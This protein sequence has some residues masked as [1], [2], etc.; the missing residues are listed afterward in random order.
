MVT[1]HIVVEK[2]VRVPEIVE[3]LVPVERIITKA[4]PVGIPVPQVGFVIL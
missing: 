2:P 4:V 3:K 1:K